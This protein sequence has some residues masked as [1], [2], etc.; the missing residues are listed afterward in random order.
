MLWNYH[1]N[2]TEVTEYLAK[3]LEKNLKARGHEV[4]LKP[5][6]DDASFQAAAKRFPRYSDFRAFG[7]IP[8]REHIARLKKD[9]PGAVIFDLHT[10]T[11]VNYLRYPHHSEIINKPK[12]W[13]ARTASSKFV[14]ESQ[15]LAIQEN[16]FN[17]PGVFAVEIP[18]KHVDIG[19]KN[20]DSDVR[21]LLRD[22][23]RAIVMPSAYDHFEKYFTERASLK[24]TKA[25]N[26]LAP[27]IIRKLAHLIDAK[28][29]TE[30]GRYRRP[31]GP[32][33]KVA[34]KKPKIRR[35]PKA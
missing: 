3:E 29:N 27:I 18:A 22:A 16:H 6:P 25:A 26:Y 10:S 19:R 11:D 20:L 1:T 32:L 35:T 17:E 24:K 4:L 23:D 13:K 5:F 8:S 14:S 34:P 2:E 33:F 7:G 28:A 30:A 31:R 15:L 9:N 21:D 12:A